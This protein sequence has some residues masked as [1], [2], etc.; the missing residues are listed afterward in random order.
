MYALHIVD[1]WR[2]SR[3]VAIE[4]QNGFGLSMC[5]TIFGMRKACTTIVLLFINLVI[6]STDL[7]CSTESCL[8]STCQRSCWVRSDLRTAVATTSQ[9]KSTSLCRSTLPAVSAVQMGD[10]Y[11]I[12][13]G[14]TTVCCHGFTLTGALFAAAVNKHHNV[15]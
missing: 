8:C 15:L 5:L 13:A 6:T 9:R 11:K 10:L 4:P 1:C 3:F 2:H 12:A 7:A 14:A